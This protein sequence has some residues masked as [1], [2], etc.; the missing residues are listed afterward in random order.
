MS[1]VI[2]TLEKRLRSTVLGVSETAAESQFQAVFMKPL[3][4]AIAQIRDPVHPPDATSVQTLWAALKGLLKDMGQCLKK[5]K[6]E[7]RF[8]S[9]RLVSL[10]GT[11]IPMPGISMFEQT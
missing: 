8:V 6:M 7:L 11:N 3:T 9:P 10:Q 1:P 4:A 5:L 2:L